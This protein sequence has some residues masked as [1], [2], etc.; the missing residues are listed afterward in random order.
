M[1]FVKAG[2]RAGER[3]FLLGEALETMG[4]VAMGRRR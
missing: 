2:V 4:L 1:M 3:L